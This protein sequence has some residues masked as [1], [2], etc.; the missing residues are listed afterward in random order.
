MS[1]INLYRSK[2][3]ATRGF[4]LKALYAG[5]VPFLRASPGV[6][7]SA[8]IHSVAKQLN[9]FVIDHRL[10][11]SAPEDMSGLPR[12]DDKGMAH[13][14]PF[15]GLFPIEGTEIPKGYD[16]WLIFLDEF[17][18][19]PK[20]VQAAAYKLILDRMVGQYKLH[21][22]VMIACA[23]NL[24]SDRAITTPIGTAMQSRV[25]HLEMETD[26]DEWLMDVALP[27]NY[28]RRIVAYLSQY[29][30]R[31]MDF[32]PDHNNKTFSCPRT[33]EFMD[34]LI[35]EQDVVLAD[36]P[37]Y[38]GTITAGIAVDFVA[39]CSVFNNL[40]SVETILANPEGCPVPSDNNTKWA[41][42]ATMMEKINGENFEKL[43][44]FANRFDLSFRILFFRSSMVRC[45]D[46][47]KHPAFVKALV[48]LQQYLTG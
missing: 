41:T 35:Y 5:L 48:A 1:E 6:G 7:K 43:A 27:N 20:S 19:A 10:S 21:E 23:G 40:L 26:F 29:P 34:R 2:P 14:A 4:L 47:R 39:F 45:P 22:N 24:D 36:Q 15:V 28:D 25:I 13:F 32:K 3:R 12:F 30:S 11:T 17:N 33:W 38:A 8:L 9:L 31:L 37:L 46:I 16:G 18:Q 42:I 44:V